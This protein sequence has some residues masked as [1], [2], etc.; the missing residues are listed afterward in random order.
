M[1]AKRGKGVKRAVEPV[2]AYLAEVLAEFDAPSTQCMMGVDLLLEEL[3]LSDPD[4]TERCGL[5]ADRYEIYAIEI[6][7]CAHLRLAVSLQIAKD[8]PWP[9]IVHGLVRSKEH[10]CE[11]AR[12]KAE[13]HFEL[14]HA[15][16]EAAHGDDKF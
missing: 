16:W 11:A 3:E 4:L 9:C 7:R 5:L 10:P 2:A 1:S 14:R 13:R 15:S 12:R 6:P 8:P